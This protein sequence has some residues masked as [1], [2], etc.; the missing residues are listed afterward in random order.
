[1]LED[2]RSGYT[3]QI[4]A[5]S[6]EGIS[7][8]GGLGR[9]SPAKIPQKF[10]FRNYRKVCPYGIHSW[11]LTYHPTSRHFWRWFSFSTGGIWI[12]SMEGKPM[13]PQES[14][15]CQNCHCDQFGGLHCLTIIR[16]WRWRWYIF[17]KHRWWYRSL[18]EERLQIKLLQNRCNTV[19]RQN[20]APPRMMI[21][22]LFIGF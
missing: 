14:Q 19:D 20:P 7:P 9:E 5:T 16:R 15:C 10:R 2:D 17:Y 21:I 6:T 11:K 12:R 13:L 1:M 4:I 8:N 22:P 18:D 3:G